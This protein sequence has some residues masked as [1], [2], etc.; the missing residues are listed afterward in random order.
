MD[1]KEMRLL[2]EEYSN[3]VAEFEKIE[4]KL[5][6]DRY[7]TKITAAYGHNSGGGNSFSSKVERK[8]LNNI[9]LENKYRELKNK[10]KIVEKTQIILAR[11]ER[12]VIEFMKIG[13]CK[14]ST[15]AQLMSKK[16]KYIF[17]TR[18]RAIRKMCE[19]I[20]DEYEI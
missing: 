1:E 2:I 4:D 12:K 16:E 17:D 20:G 10:I 14:L 15:I 5:H 18:N 8:A 7:N 11:D 3:N 9:R 6:N 13:F 19:F